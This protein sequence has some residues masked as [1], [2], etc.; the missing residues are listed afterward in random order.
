MSHDFMPQ[1]VGMD[2]VLLHGLPWRYAALRCAA[3]CLVI[4]QH[5]TSDYTLNDLRPLALLKGQMAASA[6]GRAMAHCV[7]DLCLVMPAPMRTVPPLVDFHV[8]WRQ[9]RPSLEMNELPNH[10]PGTRMT[11]RF[12]CCCR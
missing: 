4:S 5:I 1:S 9:A 2:G 12:A 7:D 10:F 8:R 6:S 3:L 11:A